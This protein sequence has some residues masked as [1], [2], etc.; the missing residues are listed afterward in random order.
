MLPISELSVRQTKS[1]M[2]KQV[3]HWP[4]RPFTLEISQFPADYVV[5]R[6]E[7]SCALAEVEIKKALAL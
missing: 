2:A 3:Q 7:Y 1:S 5:D 4:T 6:R